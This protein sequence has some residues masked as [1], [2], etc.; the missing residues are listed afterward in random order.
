MTDLRKILA[1]E[2]E[3]YCSSHRVDKAIPLPLSPSLLA[4][5]YT[6]RCREAMTGWCMVWLLLLGLR[7]DGVSDNKRV[8]V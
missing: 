3:I 5:V 8:I 2:A 7:L 1:F 4:S 6:E